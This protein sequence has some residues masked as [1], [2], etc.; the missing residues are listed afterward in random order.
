VLECGSKG[1]ENE[2]HRTDEGR[3]ANYQ[4]DN[5]LGTFSRERNVP[6]AT[7]QR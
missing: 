3:S 2:G 1:H 5:S 6:P 4:R 7:H